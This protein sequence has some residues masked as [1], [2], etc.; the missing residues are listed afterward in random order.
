[1][2]T[3]NRLNH[4]CSFLHCTVPLGRKQC[5][6]FS[7]HP[8]RTCMQ[9]A[10]DDTTIASSTGPSS[11]MV[12]VTYRGREIGAKKGEKLR[13]ILLRAGTHPH[14]GGLL[15]TCRG[16]GTCG[17]CAVSVT[18]ND[19]VLPAETSWREQARLSFP[20]HTTEN[21]QTKGLRLACQVR[22]VNDVIVDKFDGFWG[23]KEQ[24][25]PPLS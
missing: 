6:Q 15:I 11:P 18:P 10:S 5:G 2:S 14:N 16:L 1:M 19:H 25:L 9:S 22:V 23:H 13:N 4:I 8:S 7:K 17:T 20:P 21:S 12:T 3:L 24:L